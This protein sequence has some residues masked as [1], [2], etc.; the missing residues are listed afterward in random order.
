MG[1]GGPV[2]ELIELVDL[3]DLVVARS[4]DIVPVGVTNVLAEQARRARTRSGFLGEVLVVA[5]AGGTGGGKSSLLNAL[6]GEPVVPTGVVRPTTETA[7]AVLAARPFVD[8]DP[9]LEDLGV[10]ELVLVDAAGDVVYVDLPDF[11]STETA[12]RHVVETVLPRVDAVVWVLDP[13]KYADPV[14][15]REFLARLVPYQQAFV[16]VLNQIDRLGEE[17]GQARASLETWL[18]VD[19]F[20]D[21]EIVETVAAARGDR[22]TDVDALRTHLASRF[23]TKATAIA[24]LSADLRM[25]A[26]DGWASCRA[27]DPATLDDET[28]DRAALAAATFA[29]LGVA[30]WELGAAMGSRRDVTPRA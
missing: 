26:Q 28:R 5:L 29:S 22:T 10:D 20:D 24:K 16:F 1:G 23:D 2:A 11:D 12:H 6:V 14:L 15:H 7:T 27:V 17:A 9:L 19:G 13:E 8:L 30:A 18:A 25:V 21:P 4:D 3:L